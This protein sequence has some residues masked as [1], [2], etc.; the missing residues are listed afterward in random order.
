MPRTRYRIWEKDQPHFLTSTI[1]GW[2]PIFTRQE[3]FDIILSSWR[4]LQST[5]RMTLYGYVIMENHVHWIASSPNLPKEVGDFKSYTARQI[6]D[7]L[8]MQ[9]VTV[10]LDHLRRLKLKHK[11]DREFQLWQ[12]GSKPK[13]ITSREMMLQKLEYTHNNPVER[14]YVDEAIHWRHSSARNYAGLPGLLDVV[15]DW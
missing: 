7:L 11:T 15:M 10:F 13:Q 3:T 6:I 12:E 14:G 2:L 1:V 8:E 5:Q 9:R 4:F